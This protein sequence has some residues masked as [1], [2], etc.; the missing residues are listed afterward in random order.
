MTHE[1]WD[2]QQDSIKIFLA[3]IVIQM[4]PL[5]ALEMKIMSCADP[6]G[7]F[8][9]FATPVTLAHA[10]FL[11]MRLCMYKMYD[12]N[13]VVCSGLGL[14]GALITLHAGFKESPLNI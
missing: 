7:L 1:A 6:V 13:Y 2:Y 11:A 12:T 9:R 10:L 5:V 8:C 14:V 4:L 3:L